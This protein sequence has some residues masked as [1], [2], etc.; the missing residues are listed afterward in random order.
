MALYHAL[1][2]DHF[3]MLGLKVSRVRNP[4]P[5]F[6]SLIS[7]H[8]NRIYDNNFFFNSNQFPVCVRLRLCILNQVNTIYQVFQF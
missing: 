4:M 8:N 5:T 7:V 1:K 2:C 6:F 3:S